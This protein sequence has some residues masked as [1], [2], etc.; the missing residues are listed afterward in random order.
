[1][2]G[3]DAQ[4]SGEIGEGGGDIRLGPLQPFEHRF[5]VGDQNLRLLGQPHPPSHRFQQQYPDLRFQLRQLL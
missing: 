4:G 1:M 3:R 5:G 2:E